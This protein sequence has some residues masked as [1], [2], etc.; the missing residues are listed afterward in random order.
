[1]TISRALVGK[2]YLI[3]AGYACCILH[4]RILGFGM[5]QVVPDEDWVPLN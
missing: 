5:G 2:F 4:N 1:M 3:D